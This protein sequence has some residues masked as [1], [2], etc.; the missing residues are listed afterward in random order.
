MK[1]FFSNGVLGIL[2]VAPVLILMVAHEVLAVLA[3]GQTR[4]VTARRRL[5]LVV[6]VLVVVLAAVI[7]ARFYYLRT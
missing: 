1:A 6:G 7:I 5:T 3:G 2:V 4:F